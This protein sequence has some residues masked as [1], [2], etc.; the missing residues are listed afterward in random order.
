MSLIP[1]LLV[2]GHYVYLC[3]LSI[4]PLSRYHNK[5]SLR[6]PIYDHGVT[7]LPAIS[8]PCYRYALAYAM[9]KLDHHYP[10]TFFPPLPPL[11]V[12]VN[13]RCHSLLIFIARL[14]RGTKSNRAYNDDHHKKIFGGSL[15]RLLTSTAINSPSSSGSRSRHA[16]KRNIGN[17]GFGVIARHHEVAALGWDR[18]E[19]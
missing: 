1:S 5:S 19:R 16:L 9:D 17:V 3:S 4:L 7:A 15:Q 8:F 13:V 11:D 18:R 6:N 14:E 12:L 2:D 10:I